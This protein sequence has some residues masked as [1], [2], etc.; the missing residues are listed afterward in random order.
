[1]GVCPSASGRFDCLLCSALRH[2]TLESL[3]DHRPVQQASGQVDS[4]RFDSIRSLSSS[5]CSYYDVFWLFY[6]IQYRTV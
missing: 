3:F 4:I 6:S 1:M 2:S 5:N